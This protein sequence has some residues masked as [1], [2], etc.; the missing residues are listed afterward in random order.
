[1]QGAPLAEATHSQLTSAGVH[2]VHAAGE[3]TPTV[4]P[5]SSISTR[6]RWAVIQII[7]FMNGGDHW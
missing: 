7:E 1:M 5:A 4:G 3:A 6:M 2:Q